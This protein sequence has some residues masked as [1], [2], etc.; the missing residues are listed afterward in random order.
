MI[1]ITDQYNHNGSSAEQH[2][3]E[4][5]TILAHE[6][7]QLCTYMYMYVY[8]YIYIYIY[9]YMTDEY[10]NHTKHLQLYKSMHYLCTRHLHTYAAS[11]LI[12]SRASR[13]IISNTHTF[14]IW[15]THLNTH[16]DAL[17]LIR[18]WPLAIS[19]ATDVL[20]NI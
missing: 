3:H 15:Q 12:P 9:I 10:F 5:V 13:N 2:A 1:H 16:P 20:F 7:I 11:T 17:K 19:W 6:W 4:L 14:H 8:I 18:P